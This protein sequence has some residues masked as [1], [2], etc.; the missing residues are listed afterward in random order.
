MYCFTWILVR[1]TYEYQWFSPS[2]G[3]LSMIF[4]CGGEL[5]LSTP[6]LFLVWK[7]LE[8]YVVCYEVACG[9]IEGRQIGHSPPVIM[10]SERPS[11]GGFSQTCSSNEQ[12]GSRTI[13]R[14]RSENMCLS[15]Y[16]HGNRPTGFVNSDIM[17]VAMLCGSR[18]VSP[19]RGQ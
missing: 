2:N 19:V 7:E 18:K 6:P 17:Y 1:I 4:I 10:W 13:L 11:P 12:Q 5:F 9:G 14:L 3:D 16:I 8:I 15:V